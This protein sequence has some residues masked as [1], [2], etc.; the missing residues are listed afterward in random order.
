MNTFVAWCG[1][2][3]FDLTFIEVMPLGDLGNENRPAQFLPLSEVRD[4]L[5]QSWT[6]KQSQHQTGGPSRY[7]EVAETGQ[8]IGFISPLTQNFCDGCNRVRITCTGQL[9]L[10]LGHEE[11][12]DLR[13]VLRSSEGTGAV[14]EAIVEALRLKPQRHDFV[15]AEGA[16]LP[17]PG[18][19]PSRGGDEYLLKYPASG[20]F[21]VRMTRWV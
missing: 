9:V 8:R 6:L 11:G 21:T 13:A 14:K 19:C 1:A 12:K 20:G 16:A 10:C 2:E 15:I 18:I 7:V 4:R 5:S 17:C 3:G